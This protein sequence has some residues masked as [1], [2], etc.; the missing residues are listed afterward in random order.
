[1]DVAVGQKNVFFSQKYQIDLKPLRWFALTALGLLA[2]SVSFESAWALQENQPIQSSG[3]KE[4]WNRQAN[5]VELIGDAIVRQPGESLQGDYIVLDQNL[6]TLDCRTNCIYITESTIIY[7]D[8]MHFNLDTRTGTVVGGRIATDRFTLAGERINKLGADRYQ[9]HWGEYSTCRDCPQSWTFLAKDVDMEIEGYAFMNDVKLKIKDDAALWIPYLIL[10]MKSRRQTGFL[11]PRYQIQSA[12]GFVFVQPFFWAINRESDMTF[13]AGMYGSRGFRGEWQGRYALSERSKGTA[14]LFYLNDRTMGNVNEDGQFDPNHNRHRFG[15]DVSQTLELPWHIE[16]KLRLVEASDNL[17]PYRFGDLSEPSEAQL[18][19]SL[20]FNYTNPNFSANVGAKHYRNLLALE[21]DFRT[22]DA[23]TVQAYPI[24]NLNSNDQFLFGSP[25]LG[26]ISLG[27]INF[28]RAG[29]GYDQAS[30]IPGAI[31]PGGS[32]YD[33]GV[34]PLRKATR[35]TMAPSVYT[36]FQPLDGVSLIPSAQYNMFYYQ[37]HDIPPA[38]GTD[39]VPPLFRGYPLMQLELSTQV[40]RIFDMENPDIPRRKHLI[41]PYLLYSNIPFITQDNTHPFLRQINYAKT[42]FGQSSVSSNNTANSFTGFNFD[43]RDI[44]P[45]DTST[46][47]TDYF[48]PL[49]NSLGYGFTTQLIDRMGALDAPLPSYMV[50]LEFRLGQTFNFREFQVDQGGPE[51]FSR[52]ELDLIT[53]YLNKVTTNSTYYYYPYIPG[54]RHQLSSTINFIL[55]RGYHQR[56]LNFD[57]SIALNYSWSQVGY[58]GGDIANQ[59]THQLQAAINYSINDYI[60][61]SATAIFNVIAHQMTGFSYNLSFQSPSQCWKIST[62]VSFDPTIGHT[63]NA[64]SVMLNLTGQ[65]FEGVNEV[66][67]AGAAPA[68]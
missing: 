34:D 23:S 67:S 33:P 31:S 21:P 38:P 22:E 25:L 56:I 40:Q 8:E 9:T 1:M 51:P 27:M 49:G 35:F 44:V 10:P 37:F 58:T 45:R 50:P 19:S 43:D 39:P 36:T 68:H 5:R 30:N 48:V 7:G 11:F 59:G 47:T 15:V 20:N 63:F 53:N 29:P 17:Y 62:G 46:N 60:L 57:R 16:E 18:A 6:R 54:I 4:V 42:G 28:T 64:P 3:R 52:L 14:S 65:G 26:N 61:P 12:N 41:R 2:V 32:N 13:G 66:S 24:V 55:E